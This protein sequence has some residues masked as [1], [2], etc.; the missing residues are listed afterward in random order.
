MKLIDQHTIN[1]EAIVKEAKAFIEE[2]KEANF[3]EAKRKGFAS[4][5]GVATA[6]EYYQLTKSAARQSSNV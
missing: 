4:V 6:E 5:R 1:W 3:A 2:Q